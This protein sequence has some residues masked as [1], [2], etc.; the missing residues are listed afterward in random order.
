M[1]GNR[2]KELKVVNAWFRIPLGPWID[3]ATG[4][5]VVN[6]RGVFRSISD[7]IGVVLG[8][9]EG[10][11]RGAPFWLVLL[12]VSLLAWKVAGRGPGLFAGAGLLFIAGIGLWD[13]AMI[14]LAL[15]LT[16]TLVSMILGIPLGILA[17]RSRTLD[18][19]LRPVLDV[20]QTMPSFVYL[21]PA[22]ML[23]GIGR[24]PG[25]IATVVFAMPP[26]IRL[27]NLGI[28]QVPRDVVEAARAFGATPSQ[29]LF[30]VQLPLALPTIMAGVNQTILLSLS[31]VVIAAMIGAGGLGGV[32]LTAIQRVQI[33]TGFEGGIAI[34]ILAIVLDRITQALARNRRGRNDS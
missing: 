3:A 13:R 34:V 21:I 23:F 32:V 1:D 10:V 30:G 6:L 28:R 14:T 2:G 9:V 24:V 18:A 15:V 26:A 17:A 25:V 7:W 29:L 20:M 5:L 27:T 11:L 16:A 33:G 31:M 12:V 22:L 19:V 4:V 8:A